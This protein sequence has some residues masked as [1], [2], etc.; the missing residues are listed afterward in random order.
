MKY[1][2]ILICLAGCGSLSHGS[3]QEI[4]V[5]SVPMGAEVIV[6][7]VVYGKTPVTLKLKRKAEKYDIGIF[8]PGYLLYNTEVIRQ[9]DSAVAVGNFMIDFGLISYLLIDKQTGAAYRLVPEAINVGL[10][11]E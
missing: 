4:P 7:G 6:D 9:K 11:K 2:I 3:Y 10:I 5:S 1:I 8:I